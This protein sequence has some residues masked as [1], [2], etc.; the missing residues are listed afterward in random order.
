MQTI[1]F[2]LNLNDCVQGW[3]MQN[4]RVLASILTDIFNFLPEKGRKEGRKKERKA[5]SKWRYQDV[6]L[7]IC[8]K[9]KG[10]A[11][12]GETLSVPQLSPYVYEIFSQRL[13]VISQ[14][15]VDKILPTERVSLAALG[16]SLQE[17]GSI[18]AHG[19]AGI[20]I[21]DDKGSLSKS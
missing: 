2:S 7:R 1:P 19:S 17:G 21:A 8:P 20:H 16:V 12:K 14:L 9:G 10:G 5:E 3:F 11:K 13:L 15:F 6:E 4:F 18:H